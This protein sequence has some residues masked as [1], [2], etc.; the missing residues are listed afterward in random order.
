M[1]GNGKTINYKYNDSGIRTQKTVNNITTNYHLVGDK[2]TYEDNGTDKI[3][4]TYDSSDNLVSM[5]LNGVEY[6]YI[7]NAQNDIIGLI[8]KDGTQV[9]SYT[10]DSWGKLIS[11]KDGSGVDI[12]NDTGSVGY[13]NPYRYRGY[14]YDTEAGMYYLNA[15]YYNPEWGRF[16]NADGI[17]GTPGEL[18]SENMFA[19]CANNPINREDPSGYLWGFI[20]ELISQVSNA[21]NAL[22]PVYAVAGGAAIA[23]GP[24]PVG[25]AIGLVITTVATAGA[26]GYG[27][28][29]TITSSDTKAIPIEH[30]N[31]KKSNKPQHGYEIY[32]KNTGDVVKVGIS[33]GKIRQDGKSYRAEKQVRAF[34]RQ[35]GGDI[36]ESRIMSYFPDRQSALGWEQLNSQF[37]YAQGHSMRYHKRP[38]FDIWWDPK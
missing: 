7:R 15:R 28:Y 3:Y 33:G 4:Y 1:T 10:Y 18:L 17:T 35:D 30:G 24:L 22:K 23:D 13:K 5:N 20:K 27:I 29:K 31:G 38:G 32:N 12:T 9:A 6:Y 37:R 34:N 11:I 16:I 21:I 26:I 14:R 36:Y 8:D 25:D 19:Y 2:V